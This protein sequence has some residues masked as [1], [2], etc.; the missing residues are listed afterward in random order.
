M[1]DNIEIENSPKPLSSF[2]VILLGLNKIILLYLFPIVAIFSFLFAIFIYKGNNN[3]IGMGIIATGITGYF[4]YNIYKETPEKERWLI[5]IFKRYYITWLPGLHLLIYPIM[6]VD[7]RITVDATKVFDI[8]ME[9][10]SH[11]L[12]FKRGSA[13]LS[14][15]IFA[16]VKNPYKAAYEINIT[17]EEI[18]GIELKERDKGITR[19]PE[20]W[21]YFL[22]VKVE[23]AVRGV[24]G[25]YTI[26][27]AIQAKAEGIELKDGIVKEAKEIA[28]NSTKDLEI[29]IEQIAFS[30]II[31]SPDLEKARDAVYIE[32]QA[33]E[34]QKQTLEK[35]RIEADGEEIRQD[36]VKRGLYKL[37]SDL[38]DKNGNV[39]KE[40]DMTLG[41]AMQFEITRKTVDKIDGVTIINTGEDGIPDKTAASFGAKFGVG[42]GATAEQKKHKQERSKGEDKE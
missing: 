31:L 16:R 13:G 35:Q 39:V 1:T 38:T 2:E 22:A 19:L 27:D 8:F 17:E 9:E 23:A 30:A 28:K 25:K 20:R 34:K 33:V 12:E 26:D 40:S 11:K 10:G 29:E 42:F 5:S 18:E 41:D 4:L 21:M 6:R 7:H 37:I 24:C 36:G 15:K 32:E 3:L 14:I